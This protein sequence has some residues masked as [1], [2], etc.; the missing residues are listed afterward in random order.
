VP[1]SARRL[2]EPHG[3]TATVVRRHLFRTK[4]GHRGPWRKCSPMGSPPGRR[5][6]SRTRESS[7]WIS[8]NCGS[9]CRANQS[10][11]TPRGSCPRSHDRLI[12]RRARRPRRPLPVSRS[13]PG[14]VHAECFTGGQL[15]LAVRREAAG[16]TG[17]GAGQDLII[18]LLSPVVRHGRR[19]CRPV[20]A[21]VIP[22]RCKL[23]AVAKK[24]R[25]L[26]SLLVA[27]LLSWLPAH[28]VGADEHR[29]IIARPGQ[30]HDPHAEGEEPA[31]PPVQS[32]GSEI[33]P[34][35]PTS[36]VGRRLDELGP[37]S[38]GPMFKARLGC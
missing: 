8:P 23:R 9:I 27:A 10:E 3:S 14:D 6:G 38:V 11:R 21:S 2:S 13:P 30:G 25:R 18:A 17:R 37:L 36:N 29:P 33:R 34:A 28:D 16:V 24:I 26:W 1:R 5:I 4:A 12:A 32:Q 7:A 31:G 19:F 15:D 35:V 22:S 20:R